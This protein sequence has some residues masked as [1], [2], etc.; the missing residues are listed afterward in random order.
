MT[1][2]QL[3]RRFEPTLPPGKEERVLSGGEIRTVHAARESMSNEVITIDDSI[4]DV[5]RGD[6]SLACTRCTF[7]NKGKS[8]VCSMCSFPLYNHPQQQQQ[9]P[10]NGVCGACTFDSGEGA[11]VCLICNMPLV[12]D[13]EEETGD[14]GQEFEGRPGWAP[15]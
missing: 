3:L 10:A 15:C 11:T 14:P 1:K 7:Q 4:E 12:D 9:Q 6:D 5:P 2:G 13:V 8:L